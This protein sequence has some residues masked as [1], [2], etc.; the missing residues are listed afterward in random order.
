MLVAAVPRLATDIEALL[1]LTDFPEAPLRK[2]RASTTASAHYGFDDASGR[3]FG[4]TIQIGPGCTTS[5][6]NGRPMMLL[7]PRPTGRSLAF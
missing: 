1:V 4:A 5:L 2:V 6:V 3:G 7:V